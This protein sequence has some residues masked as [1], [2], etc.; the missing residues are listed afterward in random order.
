MIFQLVC[1]SLATF[2]PY[3]RCI[4]VERNK[5]LA[6]FMILGGVVCQETIS[7]ATIMVQ[8]QTHAIVFPGVCYRGEERL[9]H[10]K[11]FLPGLELLTWLNA[12]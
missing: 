11:L 12:G 7:E 1:C 8:M 9:V 10:L 3:S 6:Q 4:L 2:P 5:C